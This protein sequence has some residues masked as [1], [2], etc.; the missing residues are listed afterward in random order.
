M[1]EQHSY[2]L[3]FDKYADGGPPHILWLLRGY[4]MTFLRDGE[5]I[6]WG[7]VV[8]SSDIDWTVDIQTYTDDQWTVHGPI[9]T[10]SIDSFDTVVYH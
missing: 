10:I 8:S 6:A 7:T 9:V 2:K 3:I 1:T 4:N 5:K